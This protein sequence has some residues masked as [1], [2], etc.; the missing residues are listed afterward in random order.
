MQF[1]A[2]T[3]TRL[4]RGATRTG[5]SPAAAPAASSHVQVCPPSAL[6]AHEGGWRRLLAWLTAAPWG[7]REDQRLAAVRAEF[8]EALL[9]MHSQEADAVRLRLQRTRSL[10][11]M[12]HLRAAIYNI[13]AVQHSQYE[14][15]ARLAQLNRHFPT[16]SPLSGFAPLN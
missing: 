10:R 12:W 6:A 13:V 11:E 4:P 7:R 2:P 8:I 5:A 3:L 14:A 1:N 15:E 16:R 9:G